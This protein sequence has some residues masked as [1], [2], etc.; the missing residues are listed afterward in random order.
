[1]VEGRE[2]KEGRSAASPTKKERE[3]EKG[4]KMRR[5]NLSNS[6]D[7]ELQGVFGSLSDL[8]VDVVVLELEKEGKE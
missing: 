3:R 1:L 5:T 7:G 6:I 8:L 4:E 2:K